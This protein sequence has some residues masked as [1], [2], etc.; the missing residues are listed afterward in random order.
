MTLDDRN[1]PPAAP[2]PNKSIVLW[3]VEYPKI[4]GLMSLKYNPEDDG[5]DPPIIVEP[6]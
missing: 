1:C 3:T 4:V 2:G 5:A 6:K